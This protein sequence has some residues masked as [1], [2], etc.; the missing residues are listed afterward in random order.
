M[1]Q[2]TAR[3]SSRTSFYDETESVQKRLHKSLKVWSMYADLEESLKTFESTKAVYDRILDLKIANP[4]III[5][6]ALFLEEHHYF[7]ESFKVF[8]RGVA[9]FKWPNVFDVWN[10]Y[11]MKFIKRYGGTKLE[12]IRDLFEQA[13]EKC[14]AKFAKAFYLMYARLEEDHGLARHAMAIY[15]RATRAVLPEEQFEV[16]Q[17]QGFSYEA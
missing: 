5:N 13:L 17:T 6:F 2:A 4:Q 9:L 10:T 14:P 7:E 15:D 16:E 11:L 1:K 3:P 12:R 8:E